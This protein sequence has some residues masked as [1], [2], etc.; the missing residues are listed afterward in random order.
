[1]KQTETYLLKEIDQVIDLLFAIK[2]QKNLMFSKLCDEGV[3]TIKKKGKII[4]FGNGGSAADAQHL[5]TELTCKFKIK[6]NP[7]PGIALTTDT[8]ALTAIGNDFSFDQIFSRQLE[9][10]GRR[11][12][13]AIAITT[14]GNSKNLIEAAKTSKRKGIKIFSLSGNKGGRIKNYVDGILNVPSKIPS[15]IQVAEILIGQ[16]FCGYLEEFFFKKK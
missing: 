3:K 14:S 13:L 9:A 16:M 4:F 6:R 12:D 15:Q 8:S 10:L 11:G 5:A 7:L 2:N 1:M